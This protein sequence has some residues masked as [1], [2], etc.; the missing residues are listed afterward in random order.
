[1]TYCH[2]FCACVCKPTLG[3]FLICSRPLEAGKRK[4][5]GKAMWPSRVETESFSRYISHGVCLLI[6]RPSFSELIGQLY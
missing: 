1:M 3:C 2:P 6:I 4:E 5:K